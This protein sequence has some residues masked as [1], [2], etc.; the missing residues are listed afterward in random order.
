MGNTQLVGELEVRALT[1]K[2]RRVLRDEH[3]IDIIAMA[4]EMAKVTSDENGD[5]GYDIKSSDMDTLLD[6]AYPDERSQSILETM[7]L[8]EQVELYQRVLTKTFSDEEALAKK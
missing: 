1:R 7:S 5:V 6:V 8:M 3:N 2:Q 4:L